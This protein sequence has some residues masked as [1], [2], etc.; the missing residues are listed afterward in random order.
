MN[1]GGT[2]N[3]IALDAA[4]II[5]LDLRKY[6]AAHIA[7]WSIVESTRQRNDKNLPIRQKIKLFLDAEAFPHSREL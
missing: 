5:R 4:T 1:S 6:E 3:W 7:I 2:R